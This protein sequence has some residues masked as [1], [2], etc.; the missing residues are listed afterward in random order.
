MMAKAAPP[1]ADETIVALDVG[2][3]GIRA[4]AFASD[5]QVLGSHRYRYA[6]LF[7]GDGKVRQDPDTWFEGTNEVLAA[8]AADTVESGHRA[9]ALSVTSQRASV[10]PVG[11]EAHPLMD[12][13]MWQD[14][15]TVPECEL[16]GQRLSAERTYATTGLRI[17]P[18]FSA[19]RIVW[20][21]RHRPDIFARTSRFLGVQDLVTSF[22]CGEQVTD[23]SQASRTMLFDIS[24]SA[25]DQEILD[26]LEIPLAKLPPSVD[27]GTE[28]GRTTEALES[29]CGF[30][31]GVPVLLAGGDQQVAALGMG[32]IEPGAAEANTGTGSFVLT[33]VDEPLLDDQRRTLCSVAAIPGRWIAE[34]GILTTGIVY[35][36]FAREFG[37]GAPPGDRVTSWQ[38]DTR[39]QEL[40]EIVGTS[41]C[42]AHGVL[43]M[44]HF[45]GSAAPFW[46]PD[47]RGMFLNLQLATERA[48]IARAILEGIAMEMATN[49]DLLAL[50]AGEIDVVTAAGGLTELDLFNQI[51]A[52]AFG[53]PVQVSA[54]KEAT[55]RGAMLT[56]AVTLGRFH[57]H[58]HAYN[59]T[60]HASPRRYLPREE[61]TA[62]YGTYRKLRNDIHDTLLAAGLHDRMRRVGELHGREG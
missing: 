62:L 26:A 14:K 55:A 10:I 43:A 25:W 4:V 35:E 58:R 41:P 13:L 48:D 60:A 3:S 40:N 61:A 38:G 33:P 30:P 17:D 15:S 32:V 42:G 56:A 37:A 44:P 9:V 28:V 57:D 18:Y 51:Q 23:H 20:L 8:V 27:P 36:W 53:R 1:R 24:R 11:P 19:A 54:D 49:L 45:S 7:H 29:S 39:I 34:A 2:T 52:D 31:A 50:Q 6:P 46:N 22:L 16:I 47:A 5:G 12:A 21:Q 59:A